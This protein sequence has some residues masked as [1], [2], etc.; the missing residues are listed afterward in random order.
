MITQH[1]VSLRKSGNFPKKR[2]IAK[3]LTWTRFTSSNSTVNLSISFRLPLKPWSPSPKI[4]ANVF[5]LQNAKWKRN[6]FEF[7]KGITIHQVK[8]PS[9][10][11]R[12]SKVKSQKSKLIYS[13]LFGD[14][15]WLLYLRRDVL[16]ACLLIFLNLCYGMPMA[17]IPLV[18]S[19]RI[20]GIAP[21]YVEG[22]IRC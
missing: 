11:G 17:Y 16:V 20:S 19:G 9:T 15:I 21:Q 18:K 7:P 4:H 6:G 12:K 1:E 14:W 2:Y 13:R 22:A 8:N 5:E 10:A 3:I